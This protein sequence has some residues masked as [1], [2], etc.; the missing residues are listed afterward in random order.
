MHTKSQ[1]ENMMFG[2][3]DS[4]EICFGQGREHFGKRRKTLT[5]IFPLLKCFPN[6]SFQGSLTVGIVW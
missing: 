5:S 2:R 6:F 3:N 4:I 1:Y